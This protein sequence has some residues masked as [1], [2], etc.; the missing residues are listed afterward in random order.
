M[1]M[2]TKISGKLF[3]EYGSRPHQTQSE[4]CQYPWSLSACAH[5]QHHQ[6][7][8]PVTLRDD[9]PAKGDTISVGGLMMQSRRPNALQND[10]PTKGVLL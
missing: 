2:Y 6:N 5:I 10:K 9:K 4:G 8:R 3:S 1:N 7:R